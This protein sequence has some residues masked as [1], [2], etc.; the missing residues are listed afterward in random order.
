MRLYGL[1]SK[2]APITKLVI[3]FLGDGVDGVD[4]RRGHKGRVDI[5][6]ATGQTLS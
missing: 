4:M 1:H 3:Y 2:T 6:T 5:Q